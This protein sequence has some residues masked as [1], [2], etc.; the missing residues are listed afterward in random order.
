[1]QYGEILYAVEV[2][3]HGLVI[4]LGQQLRWQ[5]WSLEWLY[6]SCSSLT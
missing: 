5:W 4:P 6:Y 2:V 1:M 3:P